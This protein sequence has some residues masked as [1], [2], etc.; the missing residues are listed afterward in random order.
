MV[1]R[2]DT[3]VDGSD[4]MDPKSERIA[5]L[6]SWKGGKEG[7]FLSFFRPPSPPVFFFFQEMVE[8]ISEKGVQK[9]QER[10]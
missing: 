9:Y 6:V 3:L 2:R 8:G 4:G 1:G 10:D 7:G 5:T